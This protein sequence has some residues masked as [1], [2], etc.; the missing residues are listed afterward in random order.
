MPHGPQTSAAQKAR[1][2]CQNPLRQGSKLEVFFWKR[3]AAP[4]RGLI[5]SI[6]LQSAHTWR[7]SET[8]GFGLETSTSASTG[9]GSKPEL[10]QQQEEVALGQAEPLEKN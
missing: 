7:I 9:R 8:A 6:H 5:D 2:R 3:R 4:R 10:H 1:E